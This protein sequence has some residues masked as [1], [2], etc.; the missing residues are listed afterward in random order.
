[1]W[2]DIAG[3]EGLYRVNEDG[4]VYSV[5]RKM[6]I[7][8]NVNTNG[9]CQYSLQK[10]G[11]RR[12]FLG[13]RLVAEAFIENPHG[14]PIINHKNENKTDNR[15]ANLEWCTYSYNVTYGSAF[16]RLRNKAFWEKG[17]IASQKRVLQIF[18]GNVICEYSS[19]SE[20]HRAT[21][22]NIS[23]ISQCCMG[24]RKSAGK[25]NW[26]FKEKET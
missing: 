17:V 14:Y 10:N 12:L 18:N 7:K 8:P 16:E 23:N 19:I 24:K 13:H 3:Y 5:R 4:Q 25:Y 22:I 9:Y 2:K 21:G 26:K 11:R 20:A 6:I 1:M 15:I